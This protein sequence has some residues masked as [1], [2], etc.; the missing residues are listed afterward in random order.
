MV[1]AFG[2]FNSVVFMKSIYARP[3][4]ILKWDTGSF[5]VV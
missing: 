3:P 5:Q 1:H 2:G 4:A